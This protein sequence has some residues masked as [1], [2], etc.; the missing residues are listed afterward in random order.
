MQGT[1]PL[2][3]VNIFP[4]FIHINNNKKGVRVLD[5]DKATPKSNRNN[6]ASKS[7]SSAK[8]K[9]GG[10]SGSST[11]GKSNSTAGSN[12]AGKTNS[13]GKK[14]GGTTFPSSGGT[15]TNPDGTVSPTPAAPSVY[16][17][18][19]DKP[20]G[21]TSEVDTKPSGTHEVDT[22]SGGSNEVH[23]RA[24]PGGKTYPSPKPPY[25]SKPDKSE[26]LPPGYTP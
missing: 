21:S 13:A 11:A 3:P 16:P 18:A 7:G 12:A 22:K 1:F 19:G 6:A 20:T 8:G 24:K 25:K 5:D 9:S 10:T 4:Y 17:K 14:A 23:T 15:T 26:H 2:P